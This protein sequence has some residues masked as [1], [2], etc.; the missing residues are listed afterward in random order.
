MSREQ[1]ETWY[2]ENWGHTE[3]HLETL[4]ER[5]PD[6][7]Y[8]YYRLGVR[9]SH[10]A[11][12]EAT[13]QAEAKCAALAAKLSDVCAE[14]E[15]LKRA[16]SVALNILNDEDTMITSLWTSSVH[17][18]VA[19]TPATDAWVNEQRAAGAT[20]VETNIRAC[21]EEFP[22]SSRDI[23]DECIQIAANTAA[24]LRGS[25]DGGTRE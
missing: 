5:S 23:V 14:N 25:Q 4:F 17:K 19:E 16:N 1:F 18:V 6:D 20:R 15:E 12:Q 24:Q 9:M 7:H 11:W 21:Y 13:K 2:L 10:Q 3:D 8:G 22:E